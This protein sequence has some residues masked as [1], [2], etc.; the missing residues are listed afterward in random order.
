MNHRGELVFRE[1]RPTPRGDYAA[2]IETIVALVEQA[3][4]QTDQACTVGI[5]IPGAVSATSGRVKNANS[6]WLIGQPLETDLSRAL[7]QS[8]RLANDADCFTLSEATDG[9][10]AGAYSVFGIIVGTGT[11]GGL[12]VDG[13]LIRGRNAIA[14]EWGHNPLPWPQQPSPPQSPARSPVRPQDPQ[15]PAMID[16]RPG[17]ACYCGKHGCIETWL[18][19]PGFAADHQ[20]QTNQAWSAEQI[21]QAARRG[22]HGAAHSLDRYLDRF[23]RSLAS[24]INVFDPD[25]VVIGGGMSNVDELYTALPERLPAYVFTDHLDARILKARFGDS[26][27]VRG[28]AW[29]WPEHASGVTRRGSSD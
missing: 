19:G 5:G 27:G 25:A 22:D 20:R 9:A 21:V 15:A 10:A 16:E 1:R 3:K 8:V 2:T 17:P 26:S 14:G 6:T 24:I 7:G 11:G 12:V 29:L 23:A 18:S 13:R 28:A 4:C